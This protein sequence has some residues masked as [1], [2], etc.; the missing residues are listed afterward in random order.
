M[1]N[2]KFLAGRLY[3]RSYPGTTGP[4]DQ[5]HHR[6]VRA[7]R[8][9]GTWTVKA[10]PL[11]GLGFTQRRRAAEPQPVERRVPSS[12]RTNGRRLTNGTTQSG[13]RSILPRS[14]PSPLIRATGNTPT[15]VSGAVGCWSTVRNNGAVTRYTESNSSLLSIAGLNNYII[16]G[17]TAFDE[18]GPTVGGRRRQHDSWAC[19]RP[20]GSW[21]NF[22][23]P[24]ADVCRIR[25]ARPLRRR[26]RTKVVHRARRRFCRSRSVCMPRTT[27]PIE[28]QPIPATDRRERK[29]LP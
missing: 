26:L 27:W 24:D 16:T 14:S 18:D 13:D 29:Q 12:I 20:D 11:G 19:A 4:A 21:Q 2:R 9:S 6:T 28:R 15:A 5:R 1:G 10:V 25:L 8:P 22:R 17:G 7:P 3:E 23:I